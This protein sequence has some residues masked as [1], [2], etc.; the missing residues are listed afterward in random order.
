VAITHVVLY[1]NDWNGLDETA[2]IEY[3]AMAES[4]GRAEHH[5]SDNDQPENRS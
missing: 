1:P 2:R 5:F 4:G 3:S